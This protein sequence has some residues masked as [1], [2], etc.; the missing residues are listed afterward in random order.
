MC[1]ARSVF[2]SDEILM[3]KRKSDWR[4]AWMILHAWG[5]VFAAMAMFVWWPN[6][7]TFLL[8]VCIIGARQ[9]GFGI[10]MHDA[11]HGLL[12]N[13]MRLN[14]FAGTWLTGYPVMADMYLYRPYHVGLHHRFTQQKNDPDLGLSAP[15]PITRAS[16][17][18]KVVRDLTGQT[19]YKQRKGLIKFA[20][21]RADL[22]WRQRLGKGWHRLG[23]PITA[24]V[25]LFAVLAMCGRWW[26]YPALWVAPFMTFEPLIARIRSIGEHAM[27][28][29]NDDLFRNS[30]TTYANWFARAFIAPYFVNFH[31]E[32]HLL[33]FVPCYNLSKAHQ[34]MLAKGHGPRME[35]A[36]DGYLALLARASSRPELPSQIQAAA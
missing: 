22:P 34:L 7:L 29:D 35:I 23:R 21:G 2:S 13:N 3:L 4:G 31:L 10:L 16:F 27:V 32:H 12:F 36:R 5:V 20:L 6:P 17:I 24:N 28:S 15:F 18:R 1:Q 26:L 25:I 8:A 30:R 11:A 14:D 33:Q 9:L 19:A